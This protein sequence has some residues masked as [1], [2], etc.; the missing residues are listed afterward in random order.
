MTK[1]KNNWKIIPQ[2]VLS[3]NSGIS[4]SVCISLVI[5]NWTNYRIN[6]WVQINVVIL[7]CC[8]SELC[9][10][11]IFKKGF[12]QNKGGRLVVPYWVYVCKEQELGNKIGNWGISF[13]CAC[14]SVQSA[15]L[16]DSFVQ[17]P[18]FSQ[19]SEKVFLTSHSPLGACR[20]L[21]DKLGR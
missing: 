18:G 2:K 17:G 20:Q 19:D 21:L 12:Q 5:V 4:Q 1:L 11:S 7:N 14:L 8:S 9:K 13:R 10:R 15:K 16:G 3:G 6:N